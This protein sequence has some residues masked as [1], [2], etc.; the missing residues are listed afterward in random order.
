M[1]N[2][3]FFKYIAKNK[4]SFVYGRWVVRC[5]VASLFLPAAPGSRSPVFVAGTG[6]S[7]THFLARTI[8]SHPDFANLTGGEE[9]PYVFYDV[10][11]EATRRE[12]SKKKE[13]FVLNRY[14]SLVRCAGEKR[15]VDQSHPIVWMADSVFRYF[16]EGKMI[17][18]IRDPLSVAYSTLHHKGVSRWLK[19]YKE[20]EHPNSFLGTDLVSLGEYRT[21]SMVERSTVRWFSHVKRAF[22]LEKSF[23][24][25][26][27]IISYEKLCLEPMATLQSVGEFLGVD[28]ELFSVNVNK[29]ALYKKENLC[30]SKVE[31]I[32]N[33][34]QKLLDSASWKGSDMEVVNAYIAK[35]EV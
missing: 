6:R 33:I 29:L 16:P 30:S 19:C 28:P 24:D 34:L 32:N 15:I 11:R 26:F 12:S 14:E 17:F 20:F 13:K 7:G 31:A 35:G 25:N 9:N 4:L 1:V 10:L 3:S 21:M 8:D 22:E 18:I 5:G 2:G 23:P 27:R